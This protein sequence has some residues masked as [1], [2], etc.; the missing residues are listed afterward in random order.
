[1]AK[2]GREYRRVEFAYQ[3]HRMSP[4]DLLHFIESNEFT[5]AWDDYG[6]DVEE[7]LLALQLSIMAA[8]NDPPVIDGT[9]GLRKHRL[10]FS[11][12]G[13]NR[14]DE[15]QVCYV[16]FEEYGIIYM[17]LVHI[18]SENLEFTAAERKEFAG[19]IREI[20]RVLDRRKTIS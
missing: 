6:L 12:W 1:M 8:P 11:D 3:A 16:Y 10:L 15:A 17:L 19:A 2:K 4:E 14:T 5:A 18:G 20:R 9:D 7:D 13:I